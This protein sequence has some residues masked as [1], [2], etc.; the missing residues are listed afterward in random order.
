MDPVPPRRVVTRST[1][2][3][4]YLTD[5]EPRDIVD[6]LRTMRA[7]L[8]HNLKEPAELFFSRTSRYSSEV[9]SSVASIT[10]CLCRQFKCKPSNRHVHYVVMLLQSGITEVPSALKSM[11]E[12]R[13]HVLL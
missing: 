11:E 6:F 1:S 5:E 7:H 4:T 8:F 13:G 12:V 3:R 10:D 9:K 2:T